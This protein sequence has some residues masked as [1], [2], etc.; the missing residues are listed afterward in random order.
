MKSKKILSGSFRIK[1]DQNKIK[2]YQE[3][4]KNKEILKY[5]KAQMGLFN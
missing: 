3:F 2:K 4:L 5:Q 1:M